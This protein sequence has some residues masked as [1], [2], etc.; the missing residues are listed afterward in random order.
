MEAAKKGG[1]WTF[2]N[3]LLIIERVKLGVQIKNIML[4]HVDLWVQVHDLLAGLMLEKVGKVMANFI[5]PFVKYDKNNNSSFWRKY[6]C[7]R[8]R[9]DVRQLLKK[10]IKVKK[11]GGEWCTVLFKYEKLGVFCF[12]VE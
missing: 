4:F 3:H 7:L 10:S 11:K 2:G 5:G 9:I 6:M 12:V 8:V 1:M